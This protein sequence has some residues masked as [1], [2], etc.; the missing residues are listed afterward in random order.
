MQELMKIGELARKT[1]KTSRALHLYEE[2]GLLEPQRSAG[3]FRLYG[4]DELARVYWITKLQDLGFKLAQIRGLLEAVHVG[5]A[6][7]DAMHGVRELFQNKLAE[8]REQRDRLER[9]EHDL[10]ASLAYLEACRSCH[11][12]TTDS[13][14]ACDQEAE[15]HQPQLVSGLHLTRNVSRPEDTL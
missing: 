10:Q 14:A 4:R 11:A 2:M 12:E 5:N 3:G 9:L 8:I 7:P 15:R 13:C 1:G 6:A